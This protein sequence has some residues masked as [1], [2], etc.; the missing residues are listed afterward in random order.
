[1]QA[2]AEL[3]ERR[4][5]AE[6][7]PPAVLPI[8]VLRP[9]DTD[10]T[11][12]ESEVAALV[13]RGLTNRQIAVRLVISERTADSHVGNILGKLGFTSRAQVA[14]WAVEQGLRAPAARVE[15]RS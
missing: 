4:R 2:V 5:Q 9:R 11:P 6:E 3:R 1:M 13:A 15:Q 12:R 7:P 14:A 10:L 8:A